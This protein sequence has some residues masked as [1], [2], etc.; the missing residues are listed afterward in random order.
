M[1]DIEKGHLP[2]WTMVVPVVAA[3][4]ALVKLLHL[5]EGWVVLAL[6]A[7]LL[8]G[9]VFAAVT[10]AE[11][12]ALRLGEPFGSIL[13]A[14]AVTVIEVGL[15]LSIM[16]SDPVAGQIVARDTVLATVMLV[17][18]L[19]V[20]LCL[21]LGGVRHGEQKFSTD[22]A[23]SALAVLGTLA[24]LALILPDFTTTGAGASYSRGQLLL[25]AAAALGLYAVFVFVQTVRHRDY[26]LDNA[27]VG[28]GN[29][30]PP[31]PATLA[32]RSLILLLLALFAVVILA[33]ALST[34]LAA[35]VAAAGLPPEVTGVV[36]AAV[37]LLPESIAAIRSALGNRLQNSLNLALGS[38]IASIG[39]TL[40]AVAA[41][42]LIFG[43]PIVLGVS[44][45]QVAL[46]TLTLFAA[47]LTLGT[48]RTTILQGAV[49]LTLAVAFLMVT[50]LP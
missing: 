13:L 9:S 26:F 2:V 24:G 8:L 36:V 27:V 44:P 6:A 42:S 11:V 4:L 25:V 10:H 35:G 30:H 39:L 32:R 15:I 37:V 49:H 1:L 7:P 17:L 12:L 22:G 43:L 29:P 21:V 28:E 18:N 38:G 23:A 50:V 45:A 40:P 5:T 34:P 46:L 31:P 41:A 48:G 3:G 19:I 33:K 16:L 47:I 20:G 14:V